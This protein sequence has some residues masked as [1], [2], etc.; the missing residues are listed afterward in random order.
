M[1]KTGVFSETGKLRKVIVHRPDLSLRRLTPANHNEFLF[2]DVLWVDRAIEEHNAFTDIMRE[3]GVSVYYLSDLL[4]ETFS[5]SP[6][7]KIN[8]IDGIISEKTVGVSLSERIKNEMYEMDPETLSHHLIGGM[9]LSEGLSSETDSIFRR[10]LT[11][12][13]KRPDDFILTPLPNTIYTRDSSS[14][15]YNGVNFNMMYWPGRQ[16]EVLNSE[17]I[18]KNH[19]MFKGADFEY[20]N[21]ESGTGCTF[22]TGKHPYSSIEGGDL[23]PVGKKTLLVGLSQRTKPEAVECLAK[24]LF[25]NNAA[26]RVIVCQIG[27]DR[28]HMHL[29]TV[30]T[31]LDKDIAT[32]YPEVFK[33]SLTYSLIPSE[34]DE[35]FKVREEASFTDAIEDALDIDR[36]HIIPTG[37]NSYE[38]EREQWD[39]GNNILAIRPGVV[40][41]YERNTYTNRNMEYA[42]IEVITIEGSELGRGR[43]GS[44][45]MTCPLLRDA[46]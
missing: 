25:L 40:I 12:A 41:A 11:A 16:R 9:T 19:S 8:L 32:L 22:E 10:S 30:F 4:S 28:S 26:E 15:I 21:L 1:N 37:G 31:M 18:C 35:H 20:W 29:D 44:H 34:N 39:D 5:E 17:I 2:D 3:H 24:K 13:A 45:C 14:W 38:A 7:A 36:L 6:N 27:N 33:N 23:M 46:N 42:G 43:G